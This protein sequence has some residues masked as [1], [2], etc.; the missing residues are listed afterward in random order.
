MID[1]LFFP[2][3]HI[4]LKSTKSK[5]LFQLSSETNIKYLLKKCVKFFRTINVNGE[6]RRYTNIIQNCKE[7]EIIIWMKT[8]WDWSAIW[9]GQA[10]K[11]EGRVVNLVTWCLWV[12]VPVK[13][14]KSKQMSERMKDSQW[15]RWRNHSLHL[16]H[17]FNTVTT[18]LFFL[19]LFPHPYPD[20]PSVKDRSPGIIFWGTP[21][22]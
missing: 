1:I 6:W 13:K 12:Q 4:I 20:Q 7:S 21:L 11:I 3:N 18:S 8:D 16:G 15:V 9:L 10:F 19:I 14:I 22:C 2:I 17:L 5:C